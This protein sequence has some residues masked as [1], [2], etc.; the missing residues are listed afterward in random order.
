[1]A[2]RNGYNPSLISN[3]EKCLICETTLNLNRHEIFYSAYRQKSKREGCWCYLCTV[4]HHMGPN[5]PHQSRQ[6]DL[7][8]KRM[9]QRR[10]M[11]KNGR[12]EED[13]IREFG[14][15]YLRDTDETPE[16]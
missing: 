12:T 15:S 1:M 8:L 7:Q 2:D 5:S 11:Q 13:F 14:K 3:E 10:W 6:I 4:H 16:P 9:C